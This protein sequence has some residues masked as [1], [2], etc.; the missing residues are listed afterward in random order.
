[1]SQSLVVT[2]LVESLVVGGAENLA[3]RIANG[4]AATGAPSLL[5]ALH[6]H[7]PLRTR[8]SSAVTLRELDVWRESIRRPLGFA[9]SL[10]R[11][12][13]AMLRQL[14]HDDVDVV[15]AHLPEANLWSLLITGREAPAVVATIHNNNE[16]YL[17]DRRGGLRQALRRRAYRLV[18]E[19][20]RAVVTV[21]AAVK[22]SLV[23]DLGLD[24]RQAAKLVV[25]PNGVE[26][27]ELQDGV[28][29]AVR[30]ELGLEPGEHLLLGA[31]R[32]TAQKNFIDL[33][34]VAA[35]LRDQGVAAQ[36]VIA[37]EGEER[38]LLVDRITALGLQDRVRLLGVRDD[39]E[40]LVQAADVFVLSSLW[41]GLPLVM[42]EAMAAA[43]PVAAYAIEGTRDIL[44]D[45]RTGL[46]APKGDAPAL[47]RGLGQWLEQPENRRRVGE[48]GRRLV[49]QRYSFGG[50]L[51]RLEDLYI[52][53]ARQR[54][55]RGS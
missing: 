40:R 38:Q 3:V 51:E 25:V 31:G 11:G 9:A 55:G 7:G 20:C 46:L 18:L 4:R 35:A 44:D 19:R 48:A 32:L 33:L 10:R 30:R 8:V 29:D 37:G 43:C 52:D 54:G 45:G 22:S 26:V 5:Y 6:P 42:L 39:L 1:V 49:E 47:A 2:Q 50:V 21:S 24:D 34:E 17:S 13:R 53:V 28:R 16:F 15:Q 12:R 14:R 41:E 23:D 36:V 27:P